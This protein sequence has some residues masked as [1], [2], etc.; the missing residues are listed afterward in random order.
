[1]RQRKGGRGGSGGLCYTTVRS[2]ILCDSEV[3]KRWGGG[4]GGRGWCYVCAMETGREGGGGG[5]G[6]GRGG[7]RGGGEGGGHADPTTHE[8]VI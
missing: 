7:G 8:R 3:W 6:G 5:E 2:E 1:V 4:R